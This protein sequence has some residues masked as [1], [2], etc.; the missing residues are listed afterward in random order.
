MKMTRK[1][2]SIFG[3]AATTLLGVSGF[4]GCQ[5][6]TDPEPECVYGPPS[7]MNVE[8]N[9]VPDVY[10]PPEVVDVM[11]NEVPTVYG[12]PEDFI[13]N[14]DKEQNDDSGKKTDTGEVNVGDMAPVPV[15]GPPEVFDVEDNQLEDVYGPPVMDDDPEDGNTGSNK[16]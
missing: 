11:D 9:E 15:Y 3:L 12:P 6:D 13:E 2:A 4:S 1:K 8:E 16:E 5:K 7:M 14:N 10:G